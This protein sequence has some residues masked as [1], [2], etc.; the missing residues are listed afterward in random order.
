LNDTGRVDLSIARPFRIGPLLIEPALRQVSSAGTS[1]TLQPRVMQVLVALARADGAI[2]SRDALV[3][4]CW[5]T[6]IVGDDSINR[7]ISQLRRLADEHAGGSFT[8]E[9]ITKVGYRLIGDIA[10]LP[11]PAAS[12]RAIPTISAPRRRWTMAGGI[13]IG[14]AVLVAVSGWLAFGPRDRRPVVAVEPFTATAPGMPSGLAAELRAETADFLANEKFYAVAVPRDPGGPA[15]DWRIRG[16]IAPADEGNRV[17]VFAELLRKGSDVAVAQLRVDRDV[18]QPMLARSLGLRIGRTAGCVLLGTTNPELTGGFVEAAMPAFAASCITWHD[19]TSSMA[20]R[21]DR[22]RDNAAVLPKSAYFRARLG[23]LYGDLAADGAADA[24]TLR[25]QGLE[26]VTAAEA[27]DRAQPHNFLARARLLPPQDFTG[28]EAMLQK[29][30]AGRPSDCACEYGDY[31][32]FLSSVGRN[33]EARTYATRAREK[34]PKNIP[35]LRR[36]GETAAVAGDHDTARLE[37]AQ[38]A[39]YLPDPSSLDAWRMNLG[40]WSQDWPLANAMVMRQ[41][42][43]RLRQLQASL[44]AGLATGDASMIAATGQALLTRSRNDT[45]NDR[46][47][48]TALAMAGNANEAV[49]AAGRLLAL[50]PTSIALLFEPS[51]AQARQTPA[52]AA[53]VA[54]LG[55]VNYWR[56]SGH[57]PDFCAA[58]DAP[59]ICASLQEAG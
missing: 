5:E 14:A 3:L 41:P 56:R 49:A 1:Q 27:I 28:R 31:S 38:V 2:V 58:S 47:T 51:F 26:W 45:T 50:R 46:A 11:A 55:L 20:A 29:A 32:N 44:I 24:V 13:A 10:P 4:Q 25:Q 22:F 7:V 8:I 37:L 53:L 18:Q 54:Q 16:T 42:D 35:W 12:D 40:I 17:V 34:E 39:G 52:F 33:A 57:F 36:A 9:T 23:E 43:A 19:K 6:R 59:V 48:V 30:L 15:P 21:I